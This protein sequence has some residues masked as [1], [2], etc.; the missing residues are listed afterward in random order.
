MNNNKGKKPTSSAKEGN[1][2][3]GFNWWVKNLLIA[4][5]VY[6]LCPSL[7][8]N[9]EGYEW[10]IDSYTKN[11]LEAV[12]EM[13]AQGLTSPDKILEAKLGYDYAFI[14]MIRK[15]TPENATVFYPS[16]DDFEAT[17]KL[18]GV[19]FSGNLCDKLTAVRFLY[20]RH[21]VVKEELGH[22][23]WSRK[24]THVAILGG[25]WRQLL[26][27]RTPPS[28]MV[29]VLPTDSLQAARMMQGKNK[30]R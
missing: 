24:L 7:V 13:K 8:K 17:A 1:T 20:P 15:S 22:T 10:I 21:I 5:A 6:M 12:K 23:S 4:A 14:E 30:S 29:S 27:Y 11:N 2:R 28:I 18:S 26:P 19:P 16:R 9:N 25:R 3:F